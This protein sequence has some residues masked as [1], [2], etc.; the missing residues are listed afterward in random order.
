MDNLIWIFSLSKATK[1]LQFQNFH[2]L[3]FKPVGEKKKG[4]EREQVAEG[5]YDCDE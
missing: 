5:E 1:A 4:K 2:F 3:V